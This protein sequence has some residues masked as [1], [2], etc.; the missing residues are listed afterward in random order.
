M[1]KFSINERRQ[2]ILGMLYSVSLL[3]EQPNRET[4]HLRKRQRPN[5]SSD[6][7]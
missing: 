1:E 7:L 5:K 4:K 3:L 6:V 2:T